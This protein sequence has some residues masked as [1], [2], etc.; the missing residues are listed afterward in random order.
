MSAPVEIRET[1]VSETAEGTVVQLHVSDARKDEIG[2]TFRLDLSVTLPRYTPA[3]LAQ[4]QR[5][6][7]K[8]AGDALN[9]ILERLALDIERA[10]KG[11]RRLEPK[12]RT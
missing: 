11:E 6:A 7:P 10:Q 2:A 4:L 1:I 3:L 9:P 12:V 5:E 8:A